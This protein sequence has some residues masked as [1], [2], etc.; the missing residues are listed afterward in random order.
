MKQTNKES[1]GKINRL[2]IMGGIAIL[3][4]LAACATPQR[5]GSGALPQCGPANTV[6]AEVA[7]FEHVITFNRFGAF[8]PAGMVYGLK[9]DVEPAWNS[10]AEAAALTGKIKF[11]SYKRARPLVLRV[12]EGDCLEVTFWNMLSPQP[13]VVQSDSRGV[14]RI[15]PEHALKETASQKPVPLP[16]SNDTEYPATRRA[17]MHVNGL[18]YD[19]IASDGANVGRNPSSLVQPGKKT[20]YR[21]YAKK[22]GGY[23]LYSTG[24]LAG[25]EGD[26]GQLGLGMFGSVNVQPRGSM[27]YRS[28]TTHA[29]L[30]DAAR[31][32][33]GSVDYAKIDY[34]KLAIL[35]GQNNI[36][37]SD[38][39]AVV[40]MPKNSG[41]QE[42]LEACNKRSPASSCGL[43]F[44]EFTSIFHDENKVFQA[45]YELSD[46]DNPVSKIGDG[47]AINYGSAGMGATVLANRKGIG[48][49][50]DC[51]ECK[52][53]EFFLSS[54]AN[55]DPAMILR[56]DAN[57]K[58]VEALYP[59]DPSNVHHS[60]LGDP[61]RFRNM[62]A[63]PKETHVFHLHAHQWLQDQH[64]PNASYLDSQ[65]VSPGSVF[66]YEIQYGG[67]GNRNFT[68]GD[69]IFH[70]HLYPHFAA[71][72][73]ELW[74][75]HDS[76]EDGMPGEY[77]KVKSPN[78]RLRN[79]PDGEIEGGTP[80]V[81]IV[82][83][84][85]RAL[86][87]LPSEKFRGY[88]FYIAAEK[89]HR[90]PQPPMDLALAD[91]GLELNGG[92]PRHT[93]RKAT[94]KK[95]DLGNAQQV[96]AL[97]KAKGDAEE[98]QVQEYIAK[99]T[100]KLNRDPAQLAFHRELETAEVRIIANG[101]TP[102]EQTAMDFH[103]GKLTLDF[104]GNVVGG[105]DRQVPQSWNAGGM[106][107]PRWTG[108]G[109]A[110]KN[111]AVPA[112]TLPNMDADTQFV[113]NGLREQPGAPFADPCPVDAPLRK[114]KAAYIQ[115]DMTV[116][117]YGWHDPQARMPVLEEDMAATL[118]R[119]RQPEPLFFRA[120]SGDCITF[121]A[122]N[123][124][125][126]VLNLDDFQIYSPTD[127]IGQ[128]IHL[129]KFDV[130]SSDGSGNGWNY[131][132]GT[133][134]A[135]EVRERI[136]ANNKYQQQTGG[137]QILKPVTHPMFRAG[138]AMANSTKKPL[139]LC[140]DAGG[141]D[142]N[143]WCGAQSTMQRWWADPVLNDKWQDHTLRAVFS[144]DHFG[145]SSHQQHGFYSALVVEPRGSVWTTMDKI[146]DDFP[147]GPGALPCT[148]NGA[149]NFI[150]GAK[151]GK[152]IVHP[153]RKDGGPTTYAANITFP[154]DYFDQ[155][156]AGAKNEEEKKNLKREVRREYNL[157]IAD[158]AI[159]Y[160]EN[161]RPVNPPNK[162]GE[163][164]LPHNVRYG[165]RP[166]PE[167]ISAEDPG[168][169]LFNYRNE[170]IPL[171]VAEEDKE[172]VEYKQ[173]LNDEGNMAN[174]FSSNIH[175]KSG[176]KLA[177]RKTPTQMESQARKIQRNFPNE[178]ANESE[179]GVFKTL[180]DR[181]EEERSKFMN[182][183][184]RDEK[185]RVDG[186]PATPILA[187]YQGD[188]L[189]LNLV[190]GS[191][192]EQHVFSV[193]GNKWLAQ[194]YSKNSG[195]MNGQQIGIS[196]HFEFDVE[197]PSTQA[198]Q[199]DYL[200]SSPA[201]ENLWDGA[202]GLLRSYGINTQ[203][204]LGRLPASAVTPVPDAFQG[205]GSDVCPQDKNRAPVKEKYVAAI[206]ARDLLPDGRG[207]V[208]NARFNIHD[209]NAIVFVE[210]TSTATDRKKVISQHKGKTLEPLV[211]HAA[212]GDC[213]KVT[214][215]NALP[216]DLPD[217]PKRNNAES[218]SQIRA[219]WSYNLMPPIVNGF[220]FNQLRISSHVGLSAQLV[221][222]N[223]YNNDGTH[224]GLNECSLVSPN[225]IPGSP[226]SIPDVC[227]T[228]ST[229]YIWYAGDRKVMRTEPAPAPCVEECFDE[230]IV[231]KLGVKKGVIRYTPIEFGVAALRS[232]GDVIK[233]S[234]HGAVG[235]LVI[236]PKNSQVRDINMTDKATG[237][238]VPATNMAKD[239]FDAN[240]KFLY[241][242]FTLVFHDDLSL[243]QRG[244]PMP[245]HRMADDAEDT[246]QKGFN[247]RTEPLW[248][249]NGI[250][251]SGADFN[252][253]NGVDYG[254]TLS[255]RADSNNPG[256]G[257]SCGDPETPVFYANAGEPVR[258]RIVHPGGHSRQ[259]AFA[260]YGHNWDYMPWQK[261]STV[262]G[263]N[264]VGSAQ[265]GATG[266]MGPARHFNV[267]TK[268]GGAMAA[269]GD[270][271][272]RAQENFQFHGGLWGIF[273][274]QPK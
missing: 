203:A 164:N 147:S 173:K 242:D 163:L 67:A 266:G 13:G 227:A 86:A 79:L 20:V 186:D 230:L 2:R 47:M 169:R 207:L 132:D 201:V 81:A 96:Q 214:L 51:I 198:L 208:Y 8:N 245:N 130:T 157:A 124:I 70:C 263:E 88:P 231:D 192:E 271:L 91:D 129:V 193:N 106:P 156:M 205:D 102:E 213:I 14:E 225:P 141:N 211:L 90:P 111:A 256:C 109:Y 202:W 46:E 241:R 260:L 145:P 210:T 16:R 235:A 174:V 252:E 133:L 22:E 267:L 24:A 166:K 221:A 224:V 185:S 71:G 126:S 148:Q 10:E 28:Q 78:A 138:G 253:L 268:A 40:Y 116:N 11:K 258:F 58:G 239:V 98:G 146:A 143:P 171:R 200:Y 84:P 161:L 92:L 261:N 83:I 115:F 69:S 172:S 140:A 199:T 15:V 259:H 34:A 168:T 97:L 26:G 73:W 7:A 107:A 165:L 144:H 244:I 152:P 18:D 190:Q 85:G 45:F 247:Y 103:S 178:I 222:Q 25:G 57:G 118:D 95:H 37:H 162:E 33:D 251:G 158:F 243:N 151:D 216:P 196:E 248:A 82:P 240:G 17:S 49:A 5:M 232:F 19:N 123:L 99:R 176:E 204:F 53:E 250:G 110:S 189:K 87:P 12:N 21:W 155:R 229:T 59:D 64:D 246:G 270:Y 154:K 76:F 63:G 48:P 257:G 149:L 104:W 42:V 72:M 56:R 113:I 228:G 209:P 226:N 254:D 197:V 105:Q 29:Q 179:F 153:C 273:R 195:Y 36:R 30:S 131:E 108:K 127:T 39:N 32:A 191:Q 215:I 264:E 128:H 219:S 80:N 4:L 1:N 114:Y 206:L 74:R 3:C 89:G 236:G 237:K 93:I 125:P 122:T 269:P 175:V 134:A 112:G 100:W 160:N 23:F 218:D 66:S 54:W 217:G 94:E 50:K 135:D 187:S 181:Q 75:N 35:D 233:H 274:V 234:S 43:S 41:N 194:P 184:K 61:V 150:G 255:S 9:H 52:F 120:N 121:Q 182:R 265:V 117:K 220:N 136:Q 167:G 44:R 119:T 238:K 55:G 77:D 249:R 223:S 159:L 212:A 139:G 188:P 180:I 31:Q 137:S 65:T 142:D 27:W 272:F 62:H 101:I 38:L 68:V 170:P 6:K 183:I 262:L 60:Y 177:I